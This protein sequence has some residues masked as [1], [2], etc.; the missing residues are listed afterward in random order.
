MTDEERA[1]A[2]GLFLLTMKPILYVANV[3]EDMLD[4]QFEPSTGWCRS[5][6]AQRWRP[7]CRSF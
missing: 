5:R 7:S 6:S 4:E 2:K 1:A 3:D